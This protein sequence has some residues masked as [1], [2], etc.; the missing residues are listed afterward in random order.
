MALVD[1][2]RPGAV[3]A[4]DTDSVIYYVEQHP[5]YLAVVEPSSRVEV[6]DSIVASTALINDCEYLITN[7]GDDFRKV[8][9]LN[10]LTIDEHL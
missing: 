6:A 8:E 3:V 1:E 7:N 10:V 9:G 4:L 5:R 2:L